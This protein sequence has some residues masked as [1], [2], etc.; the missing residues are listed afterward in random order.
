MS[1]VDPK[2]GGQFGIIQGRLTLTPPGVLQQFPTGAWEAEFTKAHALGMTYIELLIEFDHNP[3]NPFWQERGRRAILEKCAG[4][5]CAP[6]SVCVDYSMSHPMNDGAE[7]VQYCVDL[8]ANAGELGVSLV[9][10]PLLEGGELTTENQQ[11]FVD[12]L[13]AIA[14]AGADSGVSLALETAFDGKTLAGFLAEVDRPNVKATYD[15]GNRAAFGH[16]IPGDIR[17]LGDDIVHVHIKDKNAENQNVRLGTGLVNFM[18]VAEA[19]V[20]IGYAGNFTFETTRG[21]DAERTA[22]YNMDLVT[23]FMTEAHAASA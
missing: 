17:T 11:G 22:E 14:E 20:D 1:P 7:I 16:D 21:E 6:Y 13:R 10:L 3:D 4:N 12:P 5:A 18:S 9:I 19:L 23:Y 2:S 15:T 8:V